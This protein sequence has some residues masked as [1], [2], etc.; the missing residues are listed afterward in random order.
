MEN[1]QTSDP[2]PASQPSGQYPNKVTGKYK[3]IIVS[4][5]LVV[6]SLSL[7]YNL[8][9]KGYVF[10]P[11]DFQIIN[12]DKLP[13]TVDYS[14]LNDAIEVLN[15]KYIDKSVDQHK[16]LYGA[17][18][19]AVSSLGDPYTDFFD[20]KSLNNFQTNLKGSFDGIGASV[21][22]QN[23]N[24]VIIAPLADSPAEKAGLKAKDI[25][26]AVN[27]S[28]TAGWSVDQAVEQIRGPKGTSVTLT[29][30]RGQ[31]KPFDVKIVRQ[32]IKVKSV[33]W[34]Y[35]DIKEGDKTKKIAV[36]T[37]SQ[38][39]DDTT[40]LFNQA[41]N[42]IL[43]HSVDGIILDL[44]NNPGGYL[45][46]AVDV[47][48]NWISLDTTVVTE[49]HSDGS[50]Q[51]YKAEGNNRLTGIKT[52]ILING[53][54]ASAAEIL[55]G[56][57]HDY[58]IA[59]LVGEKSFGKGSVQE[60]VNLKDGSAIKVTVAKWITPGGVNLNHNGLDPD[61]KITLTEDDVKNG[62]DPQM[63]KAVQSVLSTVK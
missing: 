36:I 38:F 28:S 42:D 52:T 19:G 27:A 21:G 58:K 8:G 32:E 45:Q 11:K 31:E 61:D 48:S 26:S 55:S 14:L 30:I 33:Q 44:R 5:I 12:Q 29:I 20:P 53:G 51:V 15:K 54:T 47:A 18:S 6:A 37:I 4:L 3:F 7:G 59:N 34:K 46:S 40:P 39:G 49:A 1:F 24:I 10:V 23:D 63:D 13:Q 9:H 41:V 50:S 56:A 62:N 22:K 43:K 17:I 25:V 2:V 35:Q 57:L 60:L 16:I